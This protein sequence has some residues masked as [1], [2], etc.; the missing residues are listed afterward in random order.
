MAKSFKDLSP[1]WS[2]I[3]Y[4]NILD[5]AMGLKKDAQLLVE[6]NQS[7]STATS[8]LVLS[9]EETIKG[10]IVFL[11]SEGYKV[12]NS[13]SISRIF[14]DHKIRHNIA[15][16]VESL[17]GLYILSERCQKAIAYNKAHPEEIAARE[18]NRTKE[19]TSKLMDTVYEIISPLFSISEIA[20]YN[21]FKNNGLYVDYNGGISIPRDRIS[22]KEYDDVHKV[23]MS[24]LKVYQLLRVVHNPLIESR[25]KNMAIYKDI[26]KTI[27]EIAEPKYIDALFK[28]M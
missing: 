5:N 27:V 14:R 21:D 15:G 23:L 22:K 17:K 9:L 28:S 7:Y 11:H 16:L 20:N 25:T 4:P 1:E 18:K 10:I 6:V 24:I 26:K 19:E 8:L 3:I 13:K 2:K 12:Y